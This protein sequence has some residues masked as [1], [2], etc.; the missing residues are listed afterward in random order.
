[1]FILSK[2]VGWSSIL[3][4]SLALALVAAGGCGNQQAPSGPPPVAS[5]GLPPLWGDAGGPADP[6]VPPAPDTAAV[7]DAA[8]PDLAADRAAAPPDQ[9]IA[10]TPDAPA[11][12]ADAPEDGFVAVPTDDAMVCTGTSAMAKPVPVDVLVVLDRSGSMTDPVYGLQRDGGYLV[13]KWE[14]VTEA[15]N[16]F[17]MSP[18]AA[19]LHVGLSYFPPTT[20]DEC[21]VALY[22]RPSVPI[23]ALPGVAAAFTAS[24][25]MTSPGGGTPTLPALQ[26]AVQLARQREMT[27]GR[28]TA[29]ALA[30]D[31]QPNSCGSSFASVND[32]ARMA[33][34]E[35]I[36]TFVI[37]VGPS[38]Q[39]F[40]ALAAAGGTGMAYLVENATPDGL[41]MAFKAVQTQASRLACSFMVPP[42]PPGEMIDTQQVGVR[43]TPT[44]NPAAAF[45]IPMVNGRPDC[46]P[47]G[48]WFFDDILNPTAVNLCEASCMKV[49]SSGEGS[50]SLQFGCRQR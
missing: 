6:D 40:N 22:A 17:V 9:T 38:L 28:R 46:G 47:A 35:G 49:N 32:L 42:P 2:S 18:S 19:G 27:L 31:G 23:D 1:M 33:A 36:F 44:A 20:Y 41:A 12:P 5:T 24:L 10:L 21:N 11:G 7:P 25:R 48:G 43:F 29:I 8:A 14:S 15:L 34:S 4:S 16:N 3:L 13:S 26:G 45:G 37:G 39:A 30:T 50:V